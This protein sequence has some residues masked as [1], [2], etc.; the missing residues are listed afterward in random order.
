[1]ENTGLQ[2]DHLSGFL[3]Y[4]EQYWIKCQVIPPIVFSF[5]F[6]FFFFFVSR[7]NFSA[8]DRRASVLGVQLFSSMSP[9]L[10]PTSEAD[11]AA[12]RSKPFSA[13]SD[14]GDHG[15]V[16]RQKKTSSLDRQSSDDVMET[17]G[18][19]EMISPLQRRVSD[20]NSGS[21]VHVRLVP[22]S[23]MIA[24]FKRVPNCIV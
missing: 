12:P 13:S 19:F 17:S 20:L 15:V 22:D 24:S 21:T 7:R 3:S 9:T 5:P 16:M 10:P 14:D 2:H 6:F 11:S 8:K 23:P 1:M 4:L 18:T